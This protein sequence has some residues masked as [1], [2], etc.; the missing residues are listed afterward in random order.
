MVEI[1]PRHAS[2]IMNVPFHDSYGHFRIARSWLKW[3]SIDNLV[4]SLGMIVTAL[5]RY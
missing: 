5:Y 2:D 1:G 3:R 4:I